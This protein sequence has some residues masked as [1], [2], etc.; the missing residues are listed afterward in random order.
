MFL[1]R[2]YFHVDWWNQQ[3]YKLQ[4]VTEAIWEL[5]WCWRHIHEFHKRTGNN[6]FGTFFI[7]HN[8]KGDAYLNILQEHVVPIITAEILENDN[9]FVKHKITQQQ[10]GAPSHFDFRTRDFVRMFSRAVNRQ[11]GSTRVDHL[12]WVH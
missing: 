11:N 4:K 9:N 1:R 7:E 2:K 10:D 12:I 6:T 3:T 5:F 8:L